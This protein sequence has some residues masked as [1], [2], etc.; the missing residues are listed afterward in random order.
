[1][2]ENINPKAYPLANEAVTAKILQ[3]VSQAGNYRQLKK[4]ANEA[5]KAVNRGLASVVIMAADASPLEIVLHLPYLC[6]D[7]NVPY[8]FVS[9][10]HALGRACG[11]TRQAS[12][13]KE[14]EM[15]KR[16]AQ[17]AK[18]ADQ[19][20]SHLKNEINALRSQHARNKHDGEVELI[21]TEQN[22]LKKEV[23]RLVN[24][25]NRLEGRP[26]IKVETIVPAAE[27]APPKCE[28][29]EVAQ[30][31]KA[32]QNEAKKGEEKTVAKKSEKQANKKGGEVGDEK[33]P[34]VSRLD[35]RIGKILEAKKHP[36]ADSLYVESVDVG[37]DKPRTVV[38]GLV[39]YIPVEEM[40]NRMAVLLC[41]LKPVKMRG[42]LSEAMVMCAS[43]PEKVEILQPPAGAVSGDL[44][45]F[46]GYPRNPDAQ[47][48][49]KKKIFEQVAPDLKTNQD[50]V[51]TYKGIPFNV[52]NK[53]VVKTHSLANVIIK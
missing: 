16:M 8:V 53:G 30:P 50:L 46:E 29:K 13:S 7:K 11:L 35:F 25:L 12:M 36:D 41:N 2:T 33:A 1:M 51:A 22:C 24:K 52:E 6:E 39:K 38:S 15:I 21:K 34:D 32:M 9:S 26:V 19:L 28:Q 5:T 27:K 3:L 47:L 14:E 17:R 18:Q 44:V 49:P 45:T 10:R 23:T 42:V 31:Q 20:I 40:Q 37:E 4:G 43:T 48:N